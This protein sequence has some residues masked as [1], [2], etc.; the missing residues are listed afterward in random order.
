M[1]K[2]SILFKLFLLCLTLCCCISTVQAQTAVPFTQRTSHRTPEMK[3]YTMQGDFEMIGNTNL[4][5]RDYDDPNTQ[6]NSNNYV[7]FVDVD[8]DPN[9]VNSSSAN[10]KFSGENGV[11]TQCAEVVYAGLYWAG[12]NSALGTMNDMILQ[13]GQT[14]EGISCNIT[15]SN[16]TRTYTFTRNDTTHTVAVRYSSSAY[17]VQSVTWNGVALDA[18]RYS[19]ES[20]SVNGTTYRFVR[21]HGTDPI[22]LYP[23]YYIY[24]LVYNVPSDD[25]GPAAVFVTPSTITRHDVKFKHASDPSGYHYQTAYGDNIYY[26]NDADAYSGMFVGYV[27]VTDYVRQWGEG[28]YFVADICLQQGNGGNLGYSGGW[29]MVVV[30]ANKNMKYRDISIFDGF[31]HVE[32]TTSNKT[33]TVPIEG[34]KTVQVGP[35]SAKLGLMAVEGDVGITGDYM[36]MKEAH[37]DN[38][39]NLS[40]SGNTTNNFFN[41]SILSNSTRTPSFTNNIGIDVVMFNIDNPDNVLLDNEQTSTSFRFTTSQDAYV[42]FCLAYSALA[43]VPDA[44]VFSG[45]MDVDDRYWNEELQKYIFSPGDTVNFTFEVRNLGNEHVSNAKISIPLPAAMTYHTQSVEYHEGITG[46]YWLAS[47]GSN[48]TAVWEL[49]EL[50]AGDPTAVWARLKLTAVVSDDCSLYQTIQ[51]DCSISLNVNGSITGTGSLTGVDFEAPYF[52][53]G[54]YSE[55]ACEGAYDYGSILAEVDAEVY[56]TTV[57]SEENYDVRVISFCLEEI[58]NG[59]IHVPF[60]EVYSYYTPGT[61]F[62][63]E[64]PP[65]SINA[66]E[67]TA[68]E[69]FYIRA[70]RDTT[71]YAYLTDPDE[72]NPCYVIVK[73]S[74]STQTFIAPT[75][76][77]TDLH[78]CVNAVAAS[79][80]DSIT[81]GEPGYTLQFALSVNGPWYNEMFP[82]TAPTG[83]IPS[84]TTT[85]YV[86]QKNGACVDT[87][88][89]TMQVTVYEPVSL[90]SSMA[91]PSC[92]GTEF[93]LTGTPAGGTFSYSEALA[94]YISVDNSILSVLSTMPAGTFQITYANNDATLSQ[95]CPESERTVIYTHTVNQ[96]S[97]G[98]TLYPDNQL[99]CENSEIQRIYISG[100]IGTIVRWEQSSSSDNGTT[101][102]AWETIVNQRGY[103]DATDINAL[104]ESKRYKFRVLVKNGQCEAV[105][106]SEANVSFS[107]NTA[108]NAPDVTEYQYA[109]VGESYDI[110]VPTPA[111]GL[112][113]RWY[114]QQYGGTPDA[115]LQTVVVSAVNQIR[116]VSLYEPTSGCES[117]RSLVAVAN[118]LDPGEISAVGQ[119][120]CNLT[121]TATEIN[122]VHAAVNNNTP[123]NPSTGVSYKWTVSKDGGE[124]VD[125]ANANG[126][127]YTPSAYM[128]EAGVYL[129]KRYARIDDC[130]WMKSDNSW[131]LRVGN[132]IAEIT[133][134]NFVCGDGSTTLTAVAS[135]STRFSYQWMKNGV[136]IANAVGREYTTTEAGTYT[137]RV[138]YREIPECSATS[139]TTEAVTV[140]AYDAPT[141]GEIA[142][143]V[144]ICNLTSTSIILENV[145]SAS[146]GVN[147]YYSWE[148]KD[149]DTWVTI[150]SGD[151]YYTFGTHP[152]AGNSYRRAWVT[153]CGT[154]YSNVVIMTEHP[155]IAPD[156]I[157][158]TG[159]QNYCVGDSINVTFGIGTPTI[160]TAQ[161]VSYKWQTSSDGENWTDEATGTTYN[162]INAS[163]TATIHVR[164]MMHIEG[165]LAEPSNSVTL[166]VHALPTITVEDL[167]NV[168]YGSTQILE[169]KN[170]T[171]ATPYTVEWSG[172]LFA[173]PV[174]QSGINENRTEAGVNIPSTPYTATYTVTATVTDNNGC[175]TSDEATVT[176]NDNVAPKIENA[177]LNT[178]LTSTSCSFTVP[179]FTAAVRAIASDN[180]TVRSELN[181]TQSPAAGESITPGSS[182][183]TQ[184]VTVTVAD[185]P[186]NSVTKDITITIPAALTV[187]ISGNT[188]ICYGAMETFTATVSGGT[189][190]YDYEWSTGE[191]TVSITKSNHIAEGSYTVS[192]TDDNGCQADKTINYNVYNELVAG[193]I[194]TDIRVC[195]TDTLI[196]ISGVTPASGG[197]NGHYSWEKKNGNEWDV[198]GNAE[199]YSFH[200]SQSAMGTY[201]RLW[202][203]DCGTVSSNEVTLS[204]QPTITP[205]DIT[206]TGDRDYC[207]GDAINVTFGFNNPT[208]TTGQTVTYQW[209][210]SSDGTNWTDVAGET[211]REYTYSNT[212]ATAD[213]HVRYQ[214]LI[215]ECLNVSS[216]PIILNVH[217]LPQV[218]LSGPAEV[219]YD[220]SI[221]VEA[222]ATGYGTLTYAWATGENTASITNNNLTTGATYTVTVTDGHNCE[223][224]ETFS[225]T[226]NDLPII[227]ISDIDNVCYSDGTTTL[228]AALSSGEASY[229]V[230]WGGDLS[231]TTSA[232]Q[233]NFSGSSTTIEANI[234]N[235]CTATSYTVM[236]TVTD[237]NGCTTSDTATVSLKEPTVTMPADAGT[238]IACA[239]ELEAPTLP[240]VTDNCGNVLL[241]VGDP[242]IS[243]TPACEGDV[244]YT[245]TYEDCEGNSHDWVYTYT[246]ERED[247]AMPENDGS[248]V[249]CVGDITDP[250]P[251]EVEDAC[252]GTVT[253]SGPTITDSS[254]DITCNGTRTYTYTYKD[255]AGHS[256]DWVYTYRVNDSV[257]P[258]VSNCPSTSINQN[259]DDG[260]NY[261]TVTFTDPTFTDNCAREVSVTRT[262]THNGDTIEIENNKFPLGT[263]TVTYTVVDGCGNET[264]CSFNVEVVDGENP[265]IACKDNQT[266]CPDPATGTYT[267]SGTA[268]DATA[269]D[270]DEVVSITYTL[271]GATN[272]AN[273]ATSLDGVTFNQ[274]ETKVTWTA[275]DNNNLMAVCE[276]YITVRPRPIIDRHTPQPICND[277]SLTMSTFQ[278]TN[279]AGATYKWTF[280]DNSAVTG[281]TANNTPTSTFETGLLHNT[282]ASPKQVTY[283]LTPISDAGCEGSPFD[284]V[285]TV[286]PTAT[287]YDVQDQTVCNGASTQAITFGTANTGGIFS[288]EWTSTLDN[289]GL[290]AQGNG[291]INAFTAINGGLLP[292]TTTVEVTPIFTLDGTICPGTPESFTITVN[293]T[294]TMNALTEAA[295]QVIC[296][297]GTTSEVVFQT[298]NEEGTTTYTWEATGDN[299][300]LSQTRGEGNFPADL[301]VTNNGTSPLEATITVTPHFSYEGLTCDGTSA[302]STSFTIT[303]NPTATMNEVENQELCHN[304]TTAPINF[305]TTNDGG[306]VTYAWTNDNTFIGLAAS[307]TTD[308][309]EAFTAINTTTA[310]V[311]AT[312]TVT[313]TFSNDGV[314]CVGTPKTFTITVNPNPSIELSTEAS[315]PLQPTYTVNAVVSSGT[316]PFIYN[317]TG[318]TGDGATGTVTMFG[319]NDCGHEYTTTLDITDN[320]GC[321]ATETLKFTV[322]DNIAPTF[323]APANIRLYKNDTCFVDMTVVGAGDVDDEAD[324]CSTGIEATYTDEVIAG[325]CANDFTILRTWI[326]VDKCGNAAEPQTQVITIEDTTRPSITC[327]DDITQNTDPDQAYATISIPLPT[328]G[329]NCGVFTYSH[330]SEYATTGIGTTNASGIYPLGITTV[331]Y[332]VVDGCG[333]EN[334]CSFT[335]TVTDGQNP[336]M[337]CPAEI[338]VQCMDDVPASYENYEA[339]VAAGGSATDNDDIDSTS[340]TLK[341]ET[342][343]GTDCNKTILRTYSIK[344]NTGLE[345]TCEQTITVKDE[346]APTFTAPAEY[347]VY[348][349]AECNYNVDS[350]ITG[351]PSELADNCS[352]T[353]TISHVDNTVEGECEGTLVITRTW[354]VTDDCGNSTSH[355]QTINVL[356]EI[357]PTF[358]APADITLYK[359]EECFVDTTVANT[360]DVTDEDDNCSTGIEATYS[361]VV[362]L[363]CEGTYTITRTWSL[364][365]NCGNAAAD[366]VQT[367]TVLDTTRPV[368]ASTSLDRELTSTNCTFLVPDLTGEV[369]ALSSDN[370]SDAAHIT[371]TQNIPVGT[372]IVPGNSMTVV[373]TVKDDCNNTN[374]KS[375]LLTTPDP[376]AVTVTPALTTICY[377]DNTDLT[378][379]PTGGKTDYTYVWSTEE[380]TPTINVAPLANM[381]YHVTVTDANG[382]TATASSWVN[383]KPVALSMDDKT[384]YIRCNGD[385]FSV[386]PT[387]SLIPN[388][389]QYTWT[390]SNNTNVTGQSN[391]TEPVSAPISQTLTNNASTSQTVI[392][393][394]TPITNDCPGDPFNIVVSIEPTPVLTLN[395]P[396]AVFDTLDFGSVS[397]YIDPSVIG[398]ASGTHSLNWTMNITNN[399]P[400]DNIY[401]EGDNVIVWTMTDEC[402]NI[403]TCEQHVY[404]TF[405]ACPNAIDFEGNEYVGVRIGYDCWTQRN[406]ESQKYS[407]GTDI[408]GIYNYYSDVYPDVADNV[409]KFGRLYDWA[410][411]LKDGADNG[412]GHLQGICPS[413]WYLPTAE[414]YAALNAYGA[415]ALKSSLYWLDGGG[416]NT[417]GFSSLPSGY[418]D[419]NIYRYLNLMGQAYYWS[420]TMVGENWTPATALIKLHCEDIIIQDVHSDYGYSVR[421]IKER[422]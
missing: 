231:F 419:G 94:P 292:V 251:P 265:V 401:A 256:H 348:K 318:A 160:G 185:N 241:P 182:E 73:L 81:P 303:V 171:G 127:S 190:D 310:P 233:E 343:T 223:T 136:E 139:S 368:I 309:I 23:G 207:V 258:T 422:E 329:D 305:S 169:A 54:V 356:D 383:V 271:S 244:T 396:P 72:T 335:V 144:E 37:S 196:T 291:N 382:C 315:C 113:Y 333:N 149:G 411:V 224:T 107:N 293:P 80:K 77:T 209:Q 198:V 212:S 415:Y 62:F 30:Y 89:Y 280:T 5:L 255:C 43:Y 97:V 45:I 220:G 64:A 316:A 388:G 227:T 192:V 177:T 20:K 320:E 400:A 350:T 157:D 88:V 221:T 4:E 206:P 53:S 369:K 379:N 344:D 405:P 334:E 41:S 353:F 260:K 34:I 351:V 90:T 57:C 262:N 228:T 63:N 151:A 1:F 371:V 267:H 204:N 180:C 234:P 178:R 219:C 135:P 194:E 276:R 269:T 285:V 92:C 402:G 278:G 156:E 152:G 128:T 66:H 100:E 375:I 71:I 288:Y 10:L 331:T 317:W 226:V 340:F 187:D 408:P 27:E 414:K 70:G 11:S 103:L 195:N 164:Y 111:S 65:L 377:Y 249:A 325:N 40:H 378:A 312:I 96:Q 394:V 2:K 85:Y 116:Y 304:A 32:N 354:T 347:T 215:P 124:E 295:N 123:D 137:V 14:G 238:T 324:N 125:I 146:G 374:T 373:V 159:S 183:T 296:N 49:S 392:Y 326:L 313:P 117:S 245:Y 47:D 330:N 29:G 108:A 205:G 243:A 336:T 381:L 294:A 13:S 56:K 42:P 39:Q 279:H 173:T 163:A 367:I 311:T 272:T 129:F 119:T 413:G 282:T 404:I 33:L 352:E 289:I 287:M 186:G 24:E 345:A 210:I 16:R 252:G 91:T 412:Y 263:T 78:Y 346:I 254:D 17:S 22:E 218:T 380:T 44:E 36:Q 361:D 259:T 236:A 141:A 250:T 193:T 82:S 416:S 274:G 130:P 386:V 357:A 25:D 104:D 79:L 140:T 237:A 6:N 264:T 277:N 58:V 48:G 366:Q 153:D 387:G 257:A 165:C 216:N 138:A 3:V 418:Y 390:V 246:I 300:G 38:Y 188:N 225:F 126:A 398:T 161:E 302:E 170:L 230:V 199:Y 174:T 232:T 189:Q 323:T 191:S 301:M 389:T 242:V 273:P 175:T 93:Y 83:D 359:N 147:G 115:T 131:I 142:E 360:G 143:K 35:V 203:T 365:D 168:C 270:N 84:R 176:V 59:Y 338:T 158:I 86:R 214:I 181:I 268:W 118:V 21:I 239:A 75:L 155:T 275:V 7:V 261:A 349:D 229:K 290:A 51:G 184:T 406:L 201:R 407:D 8:D 248:S 102:S 308:N 76:H 74:N 26:P 67:F 179:D 266:V 31:V 362:T 391:Q 384:A 202:I 134:N 393:L 355:D 307:G 162:Y 46:S 12:A 332:T 19:V 328:G 122:S 213:V 28:D 253:V 200:Y 399:A 395:C 154:V 110:Q 341:N 112:E 114:T 397:M 321:T 197:V 342:L 172:D 376:L 52:I 132:P 298:N 99:L 364:V 61:S 101:W 420:A 409:S 385:A 150:G 9:T 299:I 18:S 314:S 106:S 55:G 247:F 281:E 69:G 15:Y 417:T 421:C 358:T 87:E 148:R 327:P 322:E 109:C 133:G 120:A 68:Q 297:G 166:N 339:F 235:V 283:S 95:Y 286:N 167:A 145:T 105:Y 306:D 337:N 284:V 217:A 211:G 222:N 60:S 98:G 372:E 121:S 370:C 363:G 319:T 208:I 410:S 240:T 50:P 403:D